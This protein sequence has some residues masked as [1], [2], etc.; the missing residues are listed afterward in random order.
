MSLTIPPHCIAAAM[1]IHAVV[2]N[3]DTQLGPCEVEPPELAIAVHELVL[4]LG[5]R[6]A[7]VD[8]REPCFALHRRLR[9][10]VSQRNQVAD[11]DDAATSGLLDRGPP[12]FGT[13]AAPA[14]QRGVQ[15]R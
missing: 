5:N 3:G 9:P 7:A 14:A 4:Q 6:Q 11:C 8:H 15:R 10:P 2:L 13:V 1:P 12:E